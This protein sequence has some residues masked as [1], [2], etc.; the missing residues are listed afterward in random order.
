MTSSHTL[1]ICRT[2]PVSTSLLTAAGSL[3]A[4]E[5]SPADR[6]AREEQCTAPEHG[7]DTWHFFRAVT[8][9]L[10][11]LALCALESNAPRSALC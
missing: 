4:Q 9:T 6:L 1:L 5:C 11:C 10:A 2:S 8:R 3:G 7:P